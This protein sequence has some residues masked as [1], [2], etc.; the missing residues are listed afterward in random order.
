M[1]LDTPLDDIFLNRSHIR[2]LRALQGLPA[3]FGASGRELARRAGITHPTALKALNVLTDVGIVIARR[4]PGGDLYAYEPGHALG[5]HIA[6]IFHAEAQILLQLRS[7]L[8]EKLLALTDKV[9]AATLFGSAVRGGS[10][11]GSDIDLAVWCARADS[12]EVDA[13]LESL[14][15]AVRERFGNRLSPL[16]RSGKEKRKS[17][18]WKRIDEEGIPLIRDGKG[19]ME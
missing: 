3:G 7:F 5:G 10:D 14:S 13:A 17:G 11:P 19:V 2:V 16:V 1:R 6:E 9:I 12:D 18:I 8:R 15:D 4:G